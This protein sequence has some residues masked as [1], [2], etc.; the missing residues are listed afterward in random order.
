MKSQVRRFLTDES[1]QDVAE[2]A[3]LLVLVGIAIAI[4][5]PSITASILSVFSRTK[6][7][8]GV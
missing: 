2:Y 7:V 1:G 5:S 4:A 6:S 8:L 3:L